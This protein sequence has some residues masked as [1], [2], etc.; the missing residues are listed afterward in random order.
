MTTDLVECRIPAC[1][2]PEL[3][4]RA[5][6]SLRAQT[7]QNWRAVVLDDSPAGEAAAVVQ[8]CADPRVS[9]RQNPRPLGAA[10]NIDSAFTARSL[11]SGRFAFVLEDDNALAP[12]FIALALAR[13]ARGDV[14][15]VSVNQI[16]VHIGADGTET[17][18]NTLRPVTGSA[19]I[20]SAERIRL[21]AFLG[22]SLPNGAYFWRLDR[23]GLDLVVGPA[24]TEPQLQECIR[25]TRVLRGIAL[26][27]EP[28]SLWSMLPATQVRRQLVTHR[29]LAANL[30]L[31][32][33][34]VLRSL[35]TPR[36]QALA[37]SAYT[38]EQLAQATRILAETALLPPRRP[39]L[40]PTKLAAALRGLARHLLYRD[41]IAPALAH[42]E[43]RPFA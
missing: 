20:W 15:V 40:Q 1:R 41:A 13:L 25:Q 2:R 24:V 9:Y 23:A 28:A 6:R 32:S 39:T 37:A 18:G 33:C 34:A 38:P 10:G 31:L 22:A 4:R 12:D 16:C 7:H 17:L 11:L 14:D 26:L 21:H 42:L 27:P 5:M 8:E 29:R 43:V 35:G 3:L 30:N 36:F 19:E